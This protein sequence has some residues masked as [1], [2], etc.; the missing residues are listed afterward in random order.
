MNIS[1]SRRRFLALSAGA[2][3]SGV[4]GIVAARR[5]PAYA[6]GTRLH[7]LQWSHF[8]PAAD[9]LFEVAG[10]TDNTGSHELNQ[11]LSARRVEAVVSYLTEKHNVPLRRIVNPTGLGSSHPV[12]DNDTA[13]GRAMNRR[14]DV[15]IL[16]N[17]A[18]QESEGGASP[19]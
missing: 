9:T 3:A 5:A 17:R 10:Y 13:D 18:I 6:Q 12:A 16:Q 7:L 19:Q 15:K 11:R 14:V 8:I 2:A 4:E 1:V